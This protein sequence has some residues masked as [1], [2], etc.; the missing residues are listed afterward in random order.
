VGG[1][2]RGEAAS[3]ETGEEEAAGG[4]CEFSSWLYAL[5]LGLTFIVTLDY[6]A[7]SRDFAKARVYLETRSGLDDVSLVSWTMGNLS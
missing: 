6:D 7:C 5:G 3:K 4:L 1:E 2:W